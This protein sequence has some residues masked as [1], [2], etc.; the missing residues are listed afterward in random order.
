MYIILII[1]GWLLAGLL[2]VY[3]K[4]RL[5]NKSISRMEALGYLLGGLIALFVSIEDAM[6]SSDWWQEKL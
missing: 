1:F 4:T 5:G 2:A 3:F 6:R